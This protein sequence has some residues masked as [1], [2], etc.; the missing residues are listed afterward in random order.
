MSRRRDLLVERVG[1]GVL[2]RAGVA[3]RTVTLDEGL[4]YWPLR[5]ETEAIF[6]PEEVAEGKMKGGGRSRVEYLLCEVRHW[7][8]DPRT[9]DLGGHNAESVDQ[10]ES[11]L[12]YLVGLEVEQR[13]SRVAG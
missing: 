5:I 10:V 7:R 2:V 8:R 13:H 12:W 4:A 11:T 6:T 3:Q 9:V 1:A